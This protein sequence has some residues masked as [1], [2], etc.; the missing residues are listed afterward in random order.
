[1]IHAWG[2]GPTRLERK[3]GPKA[4]QGQAPSLRGIPSG[5]RRSNPMVSLPSGHCVTTESAEASVIRAA[6]RGDQVRRRLAASRLVER[7]AP[8]LA[9][10]AAT[11]SLAAMVFG[12]PRA[13][14]VAAVSLAVLVVGGILL[15]ARRERDV[16]DRVAREL[17][18]AAGLEGSLRSAHWFTTGA[19]GAPDSSWLAHHLETAATRAERVNW[20]SV[21]ARP[22]ARGRW[23]MSAV[24]ALLATTLSVGPIG[25]G[26]FLGFSPSVN[27]GAVGEATQAIPA[28]LLPEVVEGM[29]ALKEGRAPSKTALAAIGQVLELAKDNEGLQRELDQMFADAG[30]RA[31]GAEGQN[32]FVNFDEEDYEMRGGEM[33]YTGE[34][35]AALALE[36]A[37]KDAASRSSAE[38]PQKEPGSESGAEA[39]AESAAEGESGEETASESGE[40][41]DPGA[42]KDVAEADQKAGQAASFS[43]LLFGKQ[44][45]GTDAKT[46]PTAGRP[47]SSALTAALH[48][49][50]IHAE[51]D[52]VGVDRGQQ[53]NRRATNAA[54]SATSVRGEAG[55]TYDRARAARP[56]AVPEA[57]RSLVQE[58]FVR[59][60]D[61]DAGRKQP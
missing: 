19:T 43:S 54:A 11:L 40:S 60:A 56:P 42:S 1:M 59:P 55:V 20:I 44:P 21:Y 23:V 50:V 58:F 27:A 10:A 35:T 31:D 13:I 46:P 6:H 4:A 36:W 47:P 3:E 52:L 32:G 34:K 25:R 38:T 48:R 39:G 22:V 41:S 57:R 26:S 45:S 49:E 53:A 5:R 2:W 24:L 7:I 51:R 33:V 12:W 30:A 17:D 29:R 61:P 37:Y 16:P 9:G 18:R 15:A 28:E 8:Y 14:G